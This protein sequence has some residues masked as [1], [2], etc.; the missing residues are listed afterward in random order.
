MGWTSF[1]KSSLFWHFSKLWIR[2]ENQYSTAS[3]QSYNVGGNF[4]T[5]VN[6]KTKH[7]KSFVITSGPLGILQS[8]EAILVG[9]MCWE[10]SNICLWREQ[11]D[12]SKTWQRRRKR[13]K[14]GNI[15]QLC[16]L[17]RQLAINNNPMAMAVPLSREYSSRGTILS[18]N[19]IEIKVENIQK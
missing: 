10:C 15:G 8:W 19:S 14:K 1:S 2:S 16:Q 11:E 12:S 4:P 13:N 3:L 7:L 17:S 9:K 5:L 6:G 18:T